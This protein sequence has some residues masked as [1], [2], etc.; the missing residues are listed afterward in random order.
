MSSLLSSHLLSLHTTSRFSSRLGSLSFFSFLFHCSEGKDDT[1]SKGPMHPH[2]SFFSSRTASF[3]SML[4]S[5]TRPNSH[6]TSQCHHRRHRPV[7][8]RER[9]SQPTVVLHHPDLLEPK[10]L[11]ELLRLI[12][13]NL[14]VHKDGRALPLLLLLRLRRILVLPV[15]RVL[16][17]GLGLETGELPRG[18][19]DTGDERRAEAL[20]PVRREDVEREDVQ[21]VRGGRRRRR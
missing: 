2:R 17:D 1:R 3:G 21:L 6:R 20:R 4:W 9:E 19:D 18:I 14:T 16:L 5:E 8:E 15:L 11:I 12:V 13:P 10:P 7:R